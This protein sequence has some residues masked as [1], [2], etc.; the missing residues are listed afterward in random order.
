MNK[1]TFVLPIIRK[2]ADLAQICVYSIFKLFNTLDIDAFYIITRED[3]IKFFS[4]LFQQYAP[5]LKVLNQN[6]I[7]QNN[8][9]ES[10]WHTQQVLKL[11][12]AN[13]INT[14]YYIILDADCYLTKKINYGDLFVDEKPILS[15]IHKHKNDW[16][17]KSCAYY[18]LDYDN[19]VPDTILNVTPQICNTNIVKELILTN[20]NI[21]QLINNGCNEFWLYFCYIIKYYNFCDIYHVDM[22][23]QLSN[24]G[25]WNVDNIKQGSIEFTINSQFND[26]TTLLTLFQSNMHIQPEIYLPIIHKNIDMKSK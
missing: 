3:E 24:N 2:D 1:I 14:K 7:Y 15:L 21:S 23:K 25:I 12:I 6:D 18:E 22:N 17:L 8:V 16:L 9:S 4:N 5:Y 19:D 10:G 13:L 20:S 26:E 11:Y